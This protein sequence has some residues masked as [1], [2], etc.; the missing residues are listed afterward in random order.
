MN[1]KLFIK[2]DEKLFQYNNEVY[3]IN[4]PLSK[5]INENFKFKFFN[6]KY[7]KI[8]NSSRLDNYS[9]NILEKK[10]C[11]LCNFLS[12][13]KLDCLFENEFESVEEIVVQKYKKNKYFMMNS[14]CIV[15]VN[16]F[17]I[18]HNLNFLNNY[19][20]KDT[21]PG[22]FKTK[23]ELQFSFFLVEQACLE[24]EQLFEEYE[25]D[26]IKKNNNIFSN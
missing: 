2:P 20:L 14:I 13:D 21:E 6:K 8:K 26:F 19:L 4:K 5:I 1:P 25:L 10:S 24:Y 9:G 7:Y 11:Y 18:A 17:L 16:L 3:K 22:K 12:E 23:N 15:D